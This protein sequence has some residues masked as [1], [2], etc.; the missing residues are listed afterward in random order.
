MPSWGVVATIMVREKGGIVVGWL[1]IL[2]C[3]VWCGVVWLLRVAKGC[4]CGGGLILG[5]G[6]DFL[7]L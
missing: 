5:E 1:L 3:V 4:L 7:A 6:G 2:L